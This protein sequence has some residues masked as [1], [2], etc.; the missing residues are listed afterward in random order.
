MALPVI[1]DYYK[2]FRAALAFLLVALLLCIC[3]TAAFAAETDLDAAETER[4]GCV[5]VNVLTSDGEIIPGGT[6]RAYCVATISE[7][8]RYDFTPEFSGCDVDFSK[9]EFTQED[10]NAVAAFAE[11][12]SVNFA[13]AEV[14][15]TGK[16]CFSDL[17]QGVYLISQDTTPS[18]YM[19]IVPFIVMIPTLE[20][21]ATIYDVTCTLKPVDKAPNL[22]LPFT[23]EKDVISRG[24]G[25]AP[26]DTPFSFTLTPDKP[27]QP[28]P[29]NTDFTPDPVTGAITVTRRGAGTV[30]FG[31]FGFTMADA[32]KTYI[33]HL[34]EL[35]GT[36]LYYTYD[37]TV[38]TVSLH[39]FVDEKGLL[40]CDR[41]IIDEGSKVFENIVFNNE[42][43]SDKQN[44]PQTGQLWWP[45]FV[46]M[47][48]GVLL[49]VMGL[50]RIRKEDDTQ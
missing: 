12:H 43:N 47:G 33:Y 46:L 19:P 3:D 50:W 14:D 44:I 48:A 9:T 21:G 25:T 4:V 37:T 49:I 34:R 24:S 5:T 32:D 16:V 6:L 17:K 11:A 42:Y 23:V 8:G 38:Y 28:M 15:N 41:S 39:L 26:T 22:M 30:D 7:D 1:M 10:S 18:G 31:S 20:N 27:G 29:K 13:V 35:K 36:A 2:S 45:V 40:K